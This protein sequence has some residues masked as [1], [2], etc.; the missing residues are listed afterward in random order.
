[1]LLATF[2]RKL[3]ESILDGRGGER[4]RERIKRN[5]FLTLELKQKICLE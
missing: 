4:E 3:P 5:G 2:W 1:V